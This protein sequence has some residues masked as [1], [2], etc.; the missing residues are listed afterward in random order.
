MEGLYENNFAFNT[1]GYKFGIDALSDEPLGYKLQK[2]NIHQC[3]YS[4]CSFSTN[5]T[6]S[7]QNS[8]KV[9][10]WTNDRKVKNYVVES[11]Q[12]LTLNSINLLLLDP[13]LSDITLS[14]IIF[15]DPDKA[16][17]YGNKKYNFL[18]EIWTIPPP[19]QTPEPTPEPTPATTPV[20]AATPA[21]TTTS[22]EI[23]TPEMTTSNTNNNDNN[24]DD[25]NDQGSDQKTKTGKLGTG[26]IV[27]IIIGAIFIVAL[28]IATIFIIKKRQIKAEKGSES[29]AQLMNLV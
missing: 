10:T 18:I 26:A 28:C 14:K 19:T 11:G 4:Y 17:R 16:K 25:N 3:V 8:S 9:T 5:I 12:T 6:S 22:K 7:G 1:K 23:I 27:G 21:Q 24:N 29:Q 13:I 20:P 15:D 2:S